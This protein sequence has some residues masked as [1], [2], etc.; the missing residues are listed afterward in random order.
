MSIRSR[1]SCFQVASFS[2]LLVAGSLS[3]LLTTGCDHPAT[4]TS[5]SA[6]LGSS[7]A[8]SAIAS[9]SAAPACKPSFDDCATPADED[10]DG[11]TPPCDGAERWAHRLAGGGDERVTSIVHA[12]D[13]SHWV[14]GI[15]Q[16]ELRLSDA[17]SLKA[18]DRPTQPVEHTAFE[19]HDSFIGRFDDD[20]KA[21]QVIQI[22]GIGDQSSSEMAADADENLYLV[23]TF[24]KGLSIGG[25]PMT[26]GKQFLNRVGYVASV[27]AKGKA[28]WYESTGGFDYAASYESEI[29][30]AHV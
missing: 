7:P 10:C 17:I 14:A 5:S 24:T 4:A 15:F 22:G 21:T 28:R 9:S 19:D 12:R 18:D 26:E 2:A 1:C 6:A 25:A 8:P 13:G 30:R 27:D 11:K 20:G 29:G 16:G 3:L 23:G